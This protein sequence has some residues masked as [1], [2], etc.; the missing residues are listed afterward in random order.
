MAVT[1]QNQTV[2]LPPAIAQMNSKL[3]IVSASG[4][5]ARAILRSRFAI[6]SFLLLI[7]M[8]SMAWLGRFRHE[9]D[10]LTAYRAALPRDAISRLQNRIDSGKITLAYDSKLGY[11]PAVLRAL[12][13]PASSQVLVFSRTSIQKDEIS[14]QTPRALYFNDETYVG[15]LPG[16]KALEVATTDPQLGPVYYT[17]LQKP[18]EMPAFFRTLDTCLKCHATRASHYVPEHLLRSVYADKDGVP[19]PDAKSYVT[20]DESPLSERWGGWYV[21][22]NHGSQR[23]MGNTFA[24]RSGG[25]IALDVESGANLLD[26]RRLVDTSPYLTGHSDIVALM[27]MAHQTHLD[28]LIVHANY[29]T[30]AAINAET[31][32]SSVPSHGPGGS[33][34]AR[35][36]IACEPLVDALLFAGEAPITAPVSGTS[37]FAIQFGTRGPFDRKHRSLREFDL[38]RRLFHYPCSYMIYSEAFDGLPS[39]AKNYVFR[40]LWAVLSSRD[41]NKA[42]GRLSPADRKAV[43]EI[44]LDTKPAFAT[45]AARQLR[46]AAIRS[47]R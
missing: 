38:K 32:S 2:L 6:G 24:T 37:G 11:L 10:P 5:F 33:L 31:A 29:Q 46:A 28:N 35:I 19:D 1:R 16:A 7:P 8:A 27:V 30:R 9:E 13:M 3:T 26:L 4:S 15:Y 36:E 22:G 43:R 39:Q 25:R 44:L 21:T 20:T 40:R 12:Q 47:D 23:H 17:L 45:F 14:P 34:A 18:R 41:Q 42:F